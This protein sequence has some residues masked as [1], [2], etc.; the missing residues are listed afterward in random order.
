MSQNPSV[1]IQ[2]H[3]FGPKIKGGIVFGLRGGQLA[4]MT[5]VLV[6]MSIAVHVG[7]T[8]LG[9][10]VG[11]LVFG[12]G[13]LVA[14]LPLRKRAL[15]EW[16]PVFASYWNR[17]LSGHHRW[18]SRAHLQGH[19]AGA[20][21]GWRR[22]QDQPPGL[23]GVEILSVTAD[24]LMGEV[25][26]LRDGK[27]FI[28][29]TRA[30]GQSFALMDHEDQARLGNA[31][32]AII[33][34]FGVA[35]SLI[36]RVGFVEQSVPEDPGAL[37]SYALE[38]VPELVGA[39]TPEDI[40]D[41]LAELPELRA[42][43]IRGYLAG[44][45]LTGPA[46]RQHECYVSLELDSS[47]PRVAR[48]CKRIG[49]GDIQRGACEVLMR[50]VADLEERLQTG[51]DLKVNGHLSPRLLAKLIKTHYNPAAR[52]QRTQL[53]QNGAEPGVHP[54]NAHPRAF[55]EYLDHVQADGAYHTTYHI[56]EFPRQ[57]VA[58]TFLVPL[59]LH[60][61][62][63]RTVAMVMEPVDPQKAGREIDASHYVRNLIRRGREHYGFDSTYR[64][65]SEDDKVDQVGEEHAAGHVSVR[66]SAYLTVSAESR[67]DLDW[68]TAEVE[69]QVA[70]SLLEAER[71]WGQQGPAFTY[72]LPLCR[73]LA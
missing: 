72:T 66:F 44:V 30:H 16:L 17:Q 45:E 38:K 25:G 26:I 56:S 41:R 4:I 14:F 22:P 59:L 37:R 24:Y 5:T 20:D 55:A 65:R 58:M 34:A 11:L 69:T 49:R 33:G 21:G 29:V 54:S 1:E 9:A 31:W 61:K 71:L 7:S 15:D 12:F 53:E 73:G 48:Q 28:G 18:L 2:R 60:T 3:R 27:R 42:N 62:A 19:L 68:A 43:H 13:I 47:S 67:E 64:Q 39:R 40:A 70:Q 35:D 6:L 57:D 46:A 10:L 8:L 36:R 50:A 63:A 32:A 51:L 23:R 52:L